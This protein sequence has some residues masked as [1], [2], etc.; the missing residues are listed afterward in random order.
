[1]SPALISRSDDLR[2]L[3]DEGYEVDVANGYLL[4]S[5]VPYVNA[6]GQV[7]YGTLI[8]TLTLAGDVTTRPSDHVVFWAGDYPCASNGSQLTSLVNNPNLQERIRDGLVATYSFSHK[9]EGGYPDYYQK[10]TTY[11]RILEGPAHVLDVDATAKT[12]P[13]LELT[14]EESV[15]CYLDNASSREGI[16]A[17]NEKLRRDRVAIVGLGGTGAY[18]LDLVAKTL[19][20]E[21]HLFD[22]D[23]FLQHNAFRSPGAPSREDLMKRPT[24]VG[25][26]A[27][28][29]SKMRR[30]IIPH[31]VHI[32]ETNVA[33]L[34]Q[35][36][37][38]FLCL[39]GGGA[40]QTIARYL[41]ENRVPFIDVGMGLYVENDA[42]YGS[43]RATTFTTSFHDHL[44]RRIPSSEGGD[45][46]YSRNIQIADMNALNA[47][48]AVIKWKKLWGF[49]V[50]LGNEH[51]TVY[52]ITTNALTNDEVP[53]EAQVNQA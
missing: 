33:D 40:K 18:V 29:Y 45:N 1:M 15:F 13:V 37:L 38:V 14:E 44:A 32:N 12:F 43:A 16:T 24:K 31:P 3:R 39:E 35:M 19:V 8:S 28:T 23:N 7:V 21:I 52:G 5:H 6:Q 34:K 26:F 11:I 47:A 27:E 49:Y 20:G 53:N 30:R 42:L 4:I 50:D 2:R 41:I 46:E 9:P 51:N 22:G 48:L 36:D 25:W 17:I 10:M